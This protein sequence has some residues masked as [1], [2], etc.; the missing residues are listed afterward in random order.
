MRP[1]QIRQHARLLLER[2][3][4]Q[5]TRDADAA[6]AQAE[7]M[8]AGVELTEARA[9]AEPTPEEDCTM[10]Q[11]C[12]ILGII[13]RRGGKITEIQYPWEQEYVDAL[14][15]QGVDMA[16][17]WCHDPRAGFRQGQL[18][19][20][21]IGT[22]KDGPRVMW[23]ENAWYSHKS[24]GNYGKNWACGGTWS[25]SKNETSPDLNLIA[26]DLAQKIKEVRDGIKS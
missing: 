16:F 3:E 26:P 23:S 21:Y 12:P 24:N 15:R 9:D 14:H 2:Y 8:L 7:K 18:V 10:T 20:I 17:E 25:R 5:C 22:K 4:G 19:R 13:T 6:R 1:G 11:E